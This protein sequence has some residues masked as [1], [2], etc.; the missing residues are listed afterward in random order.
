MK[1]P[2]EKIMLDQK[3]KKMKYIGWEIAL[4]IAIVWL[5]MQINSTYDNDSEYSALVITENSPEDEIAAKLSIFIEFVKKNKPSETDIDKKYINKGLI[6]LAGVLNAMIQNH[7]SNDSN[8]KD[9]REKL[10]NINMK[11]LND[12]SLSAGNLRVSL[13]TASKIIAQIQIY[14]FPDLAD[15]SDDLVSSAMEIEK[16]ESFDV[17][18]FRTVDFFEK[19]SN[20]FIAM[21]II[22]AQ[23][24]NEVRESFY[25][26]RSS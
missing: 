2:G 26:L 9:Q 1:R 4:L 8:M 7:Y 12:D 13:L 18:K 5:G 15:A 14:E 6:Y 17:L 23:R 21:A 11:I 24:N 22:K 10:L 20:I 3:T 19:S 25:H 16:D